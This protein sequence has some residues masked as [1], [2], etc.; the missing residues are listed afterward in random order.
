MFLC[1][2]V[3]KNPIAHQ[4][5]CLCV[6]VRVCVVCLSM[7]HSG[8]GG[9]P[10]IALILIKVFLCTEECVRMCVCLFSCACCV[11]SLM[12]WCGEQLIHAALAWLWL[13]FRMV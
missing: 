12:G 1:L 6:R 9:P 11:S 10:A 13:S 7:F 5:F 2:Q 8:N 4:V 3:P